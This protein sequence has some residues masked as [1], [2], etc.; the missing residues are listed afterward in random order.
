MKLD[1]FEKLDIN[2]GAR[3]SNYEARG[4][5]Y[6]FTEPRLSLIYRPADNHYVKLSYSTMVQYAHLLINPTSGLPADLWVPSTENIE[7]EFAQHYALGYRFNTS[8]IDIG[9]TGY[10][11]EYENLLEYSN[12]FDLFF[13]ILNEGEFIP[14]FNTS[15]EWERRVSA[16]TG[17]AYGLEFSL[18]KAFEN[19][20]INLGYAYSRSFRNFD[21]IDDGASFPYRYDREH[22]INISG[23]YKISDRWDVALKWVYGTGNAFTLAL[24]EFQTVDGINVIKASGR[25]NFRYNDYHH[26]DLHFNRV[27]Q[28]D[29]FAGRLSLGV[30]NAY[31]RL[32]PFYVYLF[33]VPESNTPSLRQV[34][35]FPVIPHVSYTLSW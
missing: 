25:N 2:I 12:A 19:A 16:G 30:Y 5:S 8:G 1:A 18:V 32:N 33:A 6:A 24:E 3:R 35:L 17:R 7:P 4:T 13:S 20:K 15:N 11:K 14:V 21:S 23:H 9:L 10:F 22:D 34:S 27:F 28:Y 29:K 31:N 26:L